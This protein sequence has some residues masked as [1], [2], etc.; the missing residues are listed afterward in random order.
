ML[1]KVFES[2]RC[3]KGAFFKKITKK[4]GINFYAYF[5]ADFFQFS[6]P[7]KHLPDNVAFVQ[8]QIN[9]A[10]NFSKD[11]Q[12]RIENLSTKK[13]SRVRVDRKTG[14]YTAVLSNGDAQDYLFSIESQDIGY[15][16][17]RVR[18]DKS[19]NDYVIPDLSAKKL[20]IGESFNLY[21]V[22]FESNSYVLSKK[23]EQALKS[24]ARYFKSHPALIV[25]LQG[26]T[27]NIGYSEDNLLLSDNRSKAVFDFLINS[28]VDSQQISYQGFGDKYPLDSNDTEIGRSKNRRTVF[29]FLSI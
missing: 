1:K 25:E 27:D 2:K 18:L 26:H 15:T 4:I 20:E 21:S 11:F 16:S 5:D 7:E 14:K 12:L 13:V 17:T 10:H 22:L 3:E 28:G 8:G 29:I 9:G 24:F 19:Q 6:I 23:D